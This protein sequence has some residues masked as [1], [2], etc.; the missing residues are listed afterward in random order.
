MI[1][2]NKNNLYFYNKKH[3]QFIVKYISEFRTRFKFGSDSLF[4][5]YKEKHRFTVEKCLYLPYATCYANDIE[6]YEHEVKLYIFELDEI[7]ECI[8]RN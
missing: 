3:E 5:R 6:L 8:P 2:L 4:N 7:L 1:E